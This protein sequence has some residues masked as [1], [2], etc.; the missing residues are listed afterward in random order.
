M[1]FQVYHFSYS[2]LILHPFLYQFV[3]FAYYVIS[4]FISVI[5]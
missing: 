4:R 1:K 5:I 2:F 3:V